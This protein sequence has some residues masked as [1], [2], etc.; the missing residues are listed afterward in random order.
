MCVRRVLCKMYMHVCVRIGT[1]RKK[2]EATKFTTP[3]NSIV[4]EALHDEIQTKQKMT[5]VRAYTYAC[6]N[7]G[8]KNNVNKSYALQLI[9]KDGFSMKKA[10]IDGSRRAAMVCQMRKRMPKHAY[11]CRCIVSHL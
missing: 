11:R 1:N 9:M 10:V 2:S 7:N 8:H 4:N 3:T 5:R 6:K